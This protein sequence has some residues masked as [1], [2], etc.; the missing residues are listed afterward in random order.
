MGVKKLADGLAD[1]FG[2]SGRGLAQQVLELGEHLLDRVAVG[3]VFGQQEQRG[4]GATDGPAHGLALVAAQIVHDDDVAGREGRDERVL[5][6]PDA[7]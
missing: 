2:C 4:A 6:L 1:G 5:S 7:R 3:G